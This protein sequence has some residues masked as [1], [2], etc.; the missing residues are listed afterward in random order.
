MV[1]FGLKMVFLKCKSDKI[2]LQNAF[3]RRKHNQII[4]HYSFAC[5]ITSSTGGTMST[6]AICNID[7]SRCIR[8]CK[9]PS[10]MHQI[11][12]PPLKKKCDNDTYTLYTVKLLFLSGYNSR[13]LCKHD[14]LLSRHR[15]AQHGRYIDTTLHLL[16]S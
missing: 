14:A 3:A 12:P 11:G 4:T 13:N 2:A 16:H 7:P 9:T 10:L 5:C 8:F 1:Q 6:F 15:P